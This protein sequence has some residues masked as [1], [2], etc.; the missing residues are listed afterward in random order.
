MANGWLPDWLHQRARIC[1]ERLALIAGDGTD[2]WT[3]SSLDRHVTKTANYLVALGVGADDRVALLMR[4][5]RT[6]VTLVHALSR[7]GAV[8]VPLNTRLAPTEIGWQLGN[9]RARWLLHDQFNALA[10]T[11][12]AR[13]AG[14]PELHLVL[15]DEN[16]PG[17]LPTQASLPSSIR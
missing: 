13:D 15:T 7:L 8:L 16:F 3:F 11:T 5:G 10:A 4:N 14:R 12:A 1:P 2:R 9:V 17:P 6:F